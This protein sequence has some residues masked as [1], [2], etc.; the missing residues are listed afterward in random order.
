MYRENADFKDSIYNFENVLIRIRFLQKTVF[1]SSTETVLTFH[2]SRVKTFLTIWFAKSLSSN[3]LRCTLTEHG[4]A[5]CTLVIMINFS[6]NASYI[7]GE[8]PS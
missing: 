1:G 6:R 8:Q 3:V 2:D 4:K 5:P 7:V